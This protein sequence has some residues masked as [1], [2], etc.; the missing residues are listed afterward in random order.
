MISAS[1]GKEVIR[2]KKEWFLIKPHGRIE[3]IINLDGATPS[4]NV[5]SHLNPQNK[6]LFYKSAYY[7][8]SALLKL[9]ELQDKANDKV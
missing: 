3:E 5:Y 8:A 6:P 4:Y 1:T 9:Q 2:F 7:L